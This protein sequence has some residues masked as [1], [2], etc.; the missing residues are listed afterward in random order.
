MFFIG[1][2]DFLEPRASTLH[3]LQAVEYI[4]QNRI[5]SSRSHIHHVHVLDRTTINKPTRGVY[6][7]T[8]VIHINMH[9]A[10]QLQIATMNESIYQPFFHSTLWVFWVFKAIVGSLTPSFL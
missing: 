10:S 4:C 3:I 1:R 8:V 2:D 7:E 9:L 5:S 6:F